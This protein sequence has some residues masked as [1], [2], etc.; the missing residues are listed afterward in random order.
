MSLV[1]PLAVFVPS[2][3]N[4]PA[5]STGS[6]MQEPFED[7]VVVVPEPFVATGVDVDVEV[8]DVPVD[9]DVDADPESPPPHAGNNVTNPDEPIRRS[10]RRR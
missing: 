9:E 6:A 10:S 2:A 1:A 7:E 8:F 4:G 3:G 5:V